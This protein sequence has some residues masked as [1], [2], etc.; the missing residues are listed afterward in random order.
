MAINERNRKN[1][2]FKLAVTTIT[3]LS[4]FSYISYNFFQNNAVNGNLYSIGLVITTTAIVLILILIFYIFIK[5]LAIEIQ[6]SYQRKKL[7]KFASWIF[8]NFFLIIPILSIYSSLFYYTFSSV[9]N[10]NEVNNIIIY[11]LLF[12]IT[13]SSL[14]LHN[15]FM[16]KIDFNTFIRENNITE[17]W[18][19]FELDEQ[20]S[21]KDKI[22]LHTYNILIV[23]IR[24]KI[25]KKISSIKPNHPKLFRY[26]V[27]DTTK[28]AEFMSFCLFEL[29]A[30]YLVVFLIIVSFMPG[31]V[32]IDVESSQ[33]KSTGPIPVSIKVTGPDT[34]ISIN[35]FKENYEHNLILKDSIKLKPSHNA[36]NTEFGNNSI[37]FGNAME[38]GMY[39]IF[40]NVTNLSEGYYEFV[41]FRN[42]EY[43]KG[44][45][46][47]DK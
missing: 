29:F 9:L 31:D 25:A 37:L 24:N 23:P 10:N 47:N 40:I 2:G 44:I 22:I 16:A 12:F 39:D 19:K 15:K 17:K 38:N 21:F 30:L 13:I 4:T 5:G 11:L 41:C 1:D 42:Y 8:Q 32:F 7:E 20:D 6:D 33:Y 3:A 35:L 28:S 34:G 45:Y 14:Y 26:I 36:N 27:K 18:R 46:L 43:V